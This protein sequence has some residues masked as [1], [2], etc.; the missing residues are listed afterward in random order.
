M[1]GVEGKLAVVT[2]ATGGIG[3][4]IAAGLAGAGAHVI[5]TGRNPELGQSVVER[6]RLKGGVANFIQADLAQGASEVAEFVQRASA[7]AHIDVLVNNAALMAPAQSFTD[8]SESEI[9]RVLALNV[10]APFL[11]TA[12][13]VPAMIRNGGGVVINVGSI[14]GVA[15]FAGG[16][17]YGASKAALHSLTRSWSAEVAADNIR[18][19]TVA[20]GPTL[21]ESNTALHELMSELTRDHPAARPGTADEVAAAV[22][23]LAGD[24]ASHIHGITLPVDGGALAGVG[25]GKTRDPF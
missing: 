1:V 2:G 22:T 4:A 20:P 9:Y 16:A 3:R 5:L 15:G 18:V 7:V 6:I 12:A 13:L 17:L 23:F 24:E 25:T 10:V 11:L 14:G 8:T 19:N 21:T